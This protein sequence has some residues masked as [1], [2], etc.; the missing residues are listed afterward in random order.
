[1]IDDLKNGDGGLPFMKMDLEEELG[2]M[3]PY[4]KHM[5]TIQDRKG[6][7]A[8]MPYYVEFN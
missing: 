6:I 7:Q 5:K 2:T 3:Y 1:L 4:F 8:I